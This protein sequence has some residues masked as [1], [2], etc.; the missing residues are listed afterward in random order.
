MIM[1]II[2]KMLHYCRRGNC[3]ADPV[4]QQKH[5]TAN[6][7]AKMLVLVL[8]AATALAYRPNLK[9]FAGWD[10]DAEMTKAAQSDLTHWCGARTTECSRK[11]CLA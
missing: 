4:G 11:I 8:L 10:H 6:N 9:H 1:K 5:S 2:I 7:F 3:A